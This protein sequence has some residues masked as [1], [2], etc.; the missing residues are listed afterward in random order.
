MCLSTKVKTFFLQDRR[1]IANQLKFP[2]KYTNKEAMLHIRE[3]KI[4]VRDAVYTEL[5]KFNK[6]KRGIHGT[7]IYTLMMINS[8]IRTDIWYKGSPKIDFYK[9]CLRTSCQ[10]NTNFSLLTR[11]FE[12]CVLNG[13]NMKVYKIIVLTNLILIT[14]VTLTQAVCIHDQVQSKN[15][16]RKHLKYED[17][18]HDHRIEKRN[19]REP[20]R[21]GPGPPPPLNRQG[22]RKI[23]IHCDFQDIDK[24]LN[25]SQERLLRTIIKDAVSTIQDI[26]SGNKFIFLLSFN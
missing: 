20:P 1:I 17:L 2:K 12:L 8:Y 26:F 11:R 3:D 25:P 7:M 23:R 24:E 13:Q 21:G 6:Y 9:Y 16:L 19:V 4:L 18:E 5:D 22:F 15:V 10:E 14:F